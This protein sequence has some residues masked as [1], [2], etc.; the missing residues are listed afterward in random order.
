MRTKSPIAAATIDHRPNA[1]HGHGW[2]AN[3]DQSRE[4]AVLGAAETTA[5]LASA[6]Q[7]VVSVGVIV[8][9]NPVRHYWSALR[10]PLAL[11]SWRA[12]SLSTP[13]WAVVVGQIG[14]VGGI[15]RCD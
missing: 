3:K 2:Q 14:V 5:H 9:A 15:E 11:V 12:L 6:I 10:A 4:L 1:L 8:G 13:A 7:P